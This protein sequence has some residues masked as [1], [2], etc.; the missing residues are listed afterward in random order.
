MSRTFNRK[1][2]M[3]DTFTN[4]F[5]GYKHEPQTCFIN[6]FSHTKH[7]LHEGDKVYAP[8]ILGKETYNHR[9]DQM[10]EYSEEMYKLGSFGPQPI[11]GK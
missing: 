1:M 2:K 5:P 10:K 7:T 8:I 11:K 4:I 9:M 6:P 3:R